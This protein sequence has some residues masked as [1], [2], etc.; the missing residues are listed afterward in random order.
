MCYTLKTNRTFNYIVYILNYPS[1]YLSA[2]INKKT[3]TIKNSYN[4]KIFLCQHK[5]N[6]SQVGLEE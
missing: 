3:A 4:H 5:T 1:N 6:C 2:I